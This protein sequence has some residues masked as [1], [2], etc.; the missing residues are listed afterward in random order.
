MSALALAS[1]QDCPPDTLVVTPPQN[2][3][4]IPDWNEWDGLEIVTWNIEHFPQAGTTTINGV[5]EIILDQLADIYALQEIDD[6]LT[7]VNQLMPLLPNY[8]YVIGQNGYS[9]YLAVLYRS[10]I[11][12]ANSVE[13]LWATSNYWNDGDQDY[14]NNARYYFASRPPLK[15][16]F[17]WQCGSSTI[18]FSL[19]NVHLKCCNDGLERRRIAALLL[20]DYLNQE[21][22]Q[23]NSN[24]IVV[25]DWNDD[26]V[27][28]PPYDAFTVLLN[29][30]LLEFVTLP[31][32][33]D[34]SNYYDSY[35]SWPSFLDHILIT[36]GLFDANSASQTTTFRLDDDISNYSTIISDHRPVGWKIPVDP[37][38]EDPPY[39]IVITE[40]MANP[41]AVSDTYGEWI[42]IYNN[43]SV[44]IELS[45]WV[46]AD[47]GTDSHS[48]DPGFDFFAIEPG[49]YMVFGRNSDSTVNGGYSADYEYSGFS[50][51][52]T[53][54]EI[55]LYDSQGRLVDEVNYNA[56]FPMA[57]GKSF[58]L[59][60]PHIDNNDPANW[61]LAFQP[62]GAGDFG[63]PGFDESGLKVDNAVSTQPG[64]IMLTDN[65][66]N[67]FNPNTT[68]RYFLPAA[69]NTELSVFSI[70]GRE[71]GRLVDNW[72][73]SGWHEITWDGSENSSS[74]YFVRIWDGE[75]VEI[76][77]IC[78]IK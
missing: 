22:S 17:S 58:F 68:I 37:Q 42:E 16:D 31:L 46:L 78:L 33:Q 70:Q 12:T 24:I 29:D 60:D 55:Y 27:D 7:F 66:P 62:F 2:S 32:A 25:G 5:A 63:T 54:D 77:K 75:Q 53:A 28:S 8:N 4:N 26:L 39:N 6:T 43:D 23:G 67:P 57:A 18:D 47:A 14:Y 9:A 65:Y 50:L 76:Q 19:I 3:W 61:Y 69:G 10:E 56:S 71:V 35:P 40:I 20:K 11:L 49:E 38:V 44:Q 34:A 36:Q 72:Q 45:A 41:D 1:A 52:N 21:I 15:I 30:P 64:K 59:G 51:A 13:E 48:I 73:V 74:L